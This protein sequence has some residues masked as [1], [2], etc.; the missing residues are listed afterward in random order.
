VLFISKT[1]FCVP[2]FVWF[3]LPF[4]TWEL[5]LL[6]PVLIKSLKAMSYLRRLFT[7][8]LPRRHGF[9]IMVVHIRFLVRYV[10]LEKAF[11][12]ALQHSSTRNH[13]PSAP[14]RTDVPFNMNCY[15]LKDHLRSQH[16]RTQ[17]H[18]T[19]TIKLLVREHRVSWSP[20]TNTQN[21]SE[22]EIVKSTSRPKTYIN[23]IHQNTSQHLPFLICTRPLF[24]HPS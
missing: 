4:K 21:G 15:V 14:F 3:L 19:P 1:I 17:S 20:N 12:Q 6:Y 8:F 9:G 5:F 10:S 13:S 22:N 2:C 24:C 7:G 16:Q 11:L 18:L 23:H